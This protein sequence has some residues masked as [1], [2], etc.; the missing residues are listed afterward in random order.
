MEDACAY[1][2]ANAGIHARSITTRSKNTYFFYAG[3]FIFVLF[4]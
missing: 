3:H 4:G 1:Y 2:S